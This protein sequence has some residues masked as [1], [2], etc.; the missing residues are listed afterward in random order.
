MVES[1]LSNAFFQPLIFEVVFKTYIFNVITDNVGL[2]FDIL[3]TVF[4]TLMFS[5]CSITAFFYIVYT[6][7]YISFPIYFI[8]C[9]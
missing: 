6:V 5:Y 2:M 9:L 8:V 7:V 3:L 4:K 1:F